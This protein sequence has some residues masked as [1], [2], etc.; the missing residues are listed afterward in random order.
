[1]TATRRDWACNLTETFDILIHTRTG[2][3]L[4]VL[5]IFTIVSFSIYNDFLQMPLLFIN[6]IVDGNMLM[7]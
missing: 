5:F 3:D 1:M 2:L 6:V 7:S 4:F